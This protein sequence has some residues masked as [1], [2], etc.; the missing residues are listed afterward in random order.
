MKSHVNSWETFEGWN[1]V[2]SA[3]FQGEAENKR[4]KKWQWLR[5][6]YKIQK[7]LKHSVHNAQLPRQDCVTPLAKPAAS[8]D[9]KNLN[10]IYSLIS[11]FLPQIT[12]NSNTKNSL[13]KIWFW[14]SIY[15]F[16]A[17]KIVSPRLFTKLINIFKSIFLVLVSYFS[18]ICT[19]NNTREI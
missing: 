18:L 17:K 13:Q 11:K 9:L 3:S 19:W 4:L 12:H 1:E 5:T 6:K 10:Q 16:L 14:Q 8:L 15:F 2:L 7:L